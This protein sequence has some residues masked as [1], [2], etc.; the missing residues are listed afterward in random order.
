MA[1][2]V[3]Q[4]GLEGRSLRGIRLENDGDETKCNDA[5]CWPYDAPP[6]EEDG[7][8]PSNLPANPED[9]PLDDE[10]AAA[11][12]VNPLESALVE[13]A[14]YYRTREVSISL[15]LSEL[16]VKVLKFPA[17]RRE[18]LDDLVIVLPPFLYGVQKMARIHA[19]DQ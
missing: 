11:D 15:P 7:E 9:E 1:K 5:V 2:T 16:F 12:E 8:A 18:D 3:I 6:S 4:L 10:D 19:L 14:A 13:A 17:D